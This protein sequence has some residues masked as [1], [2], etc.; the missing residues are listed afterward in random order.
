MCHILSCDICD[1]S[2]TYS[3]ITWANSFN[4]IKCRDCKT[5]SVDKIPSDQYLDEFYDGFSSGVSLTPEVVSKKINAHRK[6]IETFF[7]KPRNKTS[8]LDYGCGLGSGAK[9]ATE[10][11]FDAYDEKALTAAK[12]H[13]GLDEH[14][15]VRNLIN[16]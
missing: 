15:I 4:L 1:S 10:L 13:M 12:T 8:F 14:E 11:G 9:A 5:V 7:P 3:T 2:F 16:L 6:S